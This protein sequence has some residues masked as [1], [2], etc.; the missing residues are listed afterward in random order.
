MSFIFVLSPGKVRLDG[1]RKIWNIR[2]Q[3]THIVA[4]ASTRIAGGKAMVAAN[5]IQPGLRPSSGP[6]W[7]TVYNVQLQF[8]PDV[9]GVES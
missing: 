4:A 9:G 5:A 1:A 3:K 7:Y 8:T 6:V 2:K